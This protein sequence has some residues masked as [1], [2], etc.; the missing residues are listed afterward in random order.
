[1]IAVSQTAIRIGANLIAIPGDQLGTAML[2][3]GQGTEAVVF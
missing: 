3:D 2:D 1:M